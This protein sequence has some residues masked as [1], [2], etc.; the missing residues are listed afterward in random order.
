MIKMHERSVEKNI[1]FLQ[2]RKSG[3]MYFCTFQATLILFNNLYTF[4]L[5]KIRPQV[6]FPKYYFKFLV[7]HV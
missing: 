3:F 2:N 1:N 7:S 4:T 5:F 6:S